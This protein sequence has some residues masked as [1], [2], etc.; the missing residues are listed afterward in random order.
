MF[1]QEQFL[2]ATTSLLVLAPA[3][4]AT[5]PPETYANSS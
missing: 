3:L 5:R 1:D 4:F 2:T